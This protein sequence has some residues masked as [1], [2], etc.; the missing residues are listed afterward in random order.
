MT[1]FL[2]AFS[3]GIVS[4]LRALSGLAVLSWT[5]RLHRVHLEGTIFAFLSYTATPYILTAM[6][7]GELINDQLPKTPSRLIPPQFITRAVMG[8][9]CGAVIGAATQM[10]VVGSLAGLLG[11]IAGT[12]GGA[13]ARLLLARVFGA[14]L[15]AALLEDLVA[16]S[17][18][19]IVATRANP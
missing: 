10:W 17:L 16:I 18:A 15:P 5:A 2:L 11:S 1:T 8:T 12:L 7:L 14:D 9:I 13:R 19:V 6:A 4:G 3:I